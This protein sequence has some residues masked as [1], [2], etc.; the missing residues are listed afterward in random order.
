M[1]A[2]GVAGCASN[3]SPAPVAATT[4]SSGSPGAAAEACKGAQF[5]ADDPDPRCM[6]HQPSTDDAP[7]PSALK[8]SVHA[9][10]VAKSGHEAVLVVE[11]R[12][13]SGAPLTLDVDSACAWDATA[14]DGVHNSFE[15]DCGGVC[16]RGEEPSVLHVTL[17]PDGVVV[18]RVHFYAVEKRVVMGPH[19]KCEEHS[20]GGLPPGRYKVSVALPWSEPSKDTPGTLVARTVDVPLTVTP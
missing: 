1:L 15:T 4:L 20:A 2:A 9:D 3:P 19:D 13:A 12:N 6:R 5:D 7:S 14:T 16:G 11:L 18:K 17:D 10:S 8:V